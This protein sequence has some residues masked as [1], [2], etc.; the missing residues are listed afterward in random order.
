M[1]AECQQTSAARGEALPREEH[2]APKLVPQ[3]KS[4]MSVQSSGFQACGKGLGVPGSSAYFQKNTNLDL[5]VNCPSDLLITL[6][7]NCINKAC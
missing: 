6:K 4:A 2:G 7:K 5:Q 3:K 1:S